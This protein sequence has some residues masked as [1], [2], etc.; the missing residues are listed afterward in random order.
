MVYFQT[1]NVDLMVGKIQRATCIATVHHSTRTCA[2]N[3]TGVVPALGRVLRSH[4]RPSAARRGF[5]GADRGRLTAGTGCREHGICGDASDVSS[6]QYAEQTLESIKSH[7]N[8]TAHDAALFS[9]R[10]ATTE[11]APAKAMGCRAH[12]ERLD[13]TGR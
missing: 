1:C 3:T 12:S 8:P 11:K 10:A 5:P 9:R 6:Q 13:G 7:D 2:Q 4:V